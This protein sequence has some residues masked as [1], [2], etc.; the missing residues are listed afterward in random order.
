MNCRDMEMWIALRAEGDLPAAEEERV[1]EHL[2][3]C[4]ACR[5]MAAELAE[6][7]AALKALGD[8]AVDGAALA[9]WRKG[10]MDRVEAR[11]ARRRFAWG[12][13][14][15]AAAAA[16]V[17]VF[18]LS[19]VAPRRVP[20]PAPPVVARTIPPPPEALMNVPLPPGMSRGMPRGGQT[21]SLPRRH[22]RSRPPEPQSE[23]QPTINGEPLLVKLETSD[24]NVIIYW[25][26]EKKGS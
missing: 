6:S 11:G 9:A 7:Q 23:L 4:A 17:L 20:P 16:V 12:G 21:R 19:Q 14:F 22:V 10:L 15:A 8:E 2:D 26:V 24:P 18:G 25:I 1:R 3:A 5:A 13:A